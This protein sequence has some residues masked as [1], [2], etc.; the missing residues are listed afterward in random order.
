VEAAGGSLARV[1]SA[2]GF[3]RDHQV[4]G[5]KRDEARPKSDLGSGTPERAGAEKRQREPDAGR[6]CNIGN[7]SQATLSKLQSNPAAPRQRPECS[8]RPRNDD[9]T[10]QQRANRAEMPTRTDM[11]FS[12][13]SSLSSGR[14]LYL[15][16]TATNVGPHNGCCDETIDIRT[17]GIDVTAIGN[18]SDCGGAPLGRIRTDNPYPETQNAKPSQ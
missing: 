11:P 18:E 4:G 2:N 1:P 14:R 3:E 6:T 13:R 17:E 7:T 5:D 16:T 15:S 10:N 9:R 12:S 8:H